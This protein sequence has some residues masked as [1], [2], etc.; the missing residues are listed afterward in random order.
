[1]SLRL[2][3]FTYKKLPFMQLH[4]H[5]PRTRKLSVPILRLANR[6]RNGIQTKQRYRPA[7]RYHDSIACAIRS[8]Y[9]DCTGTSTRQH[10]EP[11]GNQE[12]WH[13]H[14]HVFARYPDDALYE[15]HANKRFVAPA[16]RAAYALRLSKY[17][18][19]HTV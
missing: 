16:E 3:I 19:V 10:N 4:V 1:M 15:N 12:V 14:V 17:L 13:C 7:G 8:T 9:V 6:Q 5:A 18:T 11:D 2:S